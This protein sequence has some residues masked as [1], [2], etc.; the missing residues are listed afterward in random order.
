M[1]PT[2]L[3]Q[4][5]MGFAGAF[6]GLRLYPPDHPSVRNQMQNLL[7]RLHAA[8][9]DRET[10]K[11]GILQGTLFLGDHLF[12]HGTPAADDL[13]RLLQERE[14]DALEFVR[15]ITEDEIRLF[16]EILGQSEIK[17]EQLQGRLEEQGIEHIRL[18]GG[19]GE[20]EDPAEQEPRQVYGRALT[21]VNDIFHDVRLGRIPSSRTAKKVVEDMARLTIA[22]PHALFAL[23]ML[24]NYDNYTFTHSVNVSVISLAIGRACGLAE[25]ELR[26]LGLGGLLHDIGKLKIDLA[27]INKPGRLTDGEFEKIKQHPAM[28]ATILENMEGIALPAIDIV[29]GHHLRFDRQGYPVDARMRGSL[30]MV[31]M[32]AI[33]DTYD[34][35]TT[36]RSYQRPATPREALS[37]MCRVSGTTLHP[38]YLQAFAA[39]LGTYP[40]GSMVRLASN[41]IGLVSR[42]GIDNPEEIKLKVLFDG[43]G[44]RLPEPALRYLTSSETKRI[45]AEV[46]PFLKGINPVDY[47]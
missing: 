39:S 19:R 24:K 3:K 8:L 21:V 14:V 18:A 36:L 33:A 15:G 44:R 13:A 10:L 41:E 22:D 45:V 11:M 31:D 34:A 17:G 1:N 37:Q 25:E 2:L 29:L 12:V 9:Q 46:D 42:V 38:T 43:S 35:I 47:L 40:V 28:G 20:E 6:K 4:I 7:Q 16:L 23:S 5:V 30:T 32:A 26:I 27:I